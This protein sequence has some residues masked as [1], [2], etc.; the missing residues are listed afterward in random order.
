MCLIVFRIS[1]AV[2]N[3]GAECSKWIGIGN[4]NGVGAV[5]ICILVILETKRIF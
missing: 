2:G 5:N 4:A 3:C 1:E